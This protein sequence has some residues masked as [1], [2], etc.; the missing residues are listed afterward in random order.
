MR[1][2][3]GI[4]IVSIFCAS[5][6]AFPLPQT[7][8]RAEQLQRD[9]ERLTREK[10]PVGHTKIQIAIS[11]IL[12]SFVGDAVKS[13]DIAEIQKQ[14]NDY[15][16]S[17]QDAFQTIMN[18][19]RDANR[20]PGGFKDLEIAL[21]RQINRIDDYAQVLTYE[22]RAPLS[23]AKVEAAELRDHL[24][25]ALLVEDKNAKVAP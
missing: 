21:R 11:E 14:L 24:I 1:R 13:G 12:L 6:I 5:G 20:H 10:D 17:I 18:T 23:K 15:C 8:K 9:R 7:D 4:L 25:K 16:A 3:A 2:L 22:Q 19:G